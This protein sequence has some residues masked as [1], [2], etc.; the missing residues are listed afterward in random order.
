MGS[1]ISDYEYGIVCGVCSAPGGRIRGQAQ[2]DI[3]RQAAFGRRPPRGCQAHLRGERGGRGAFAS[4]VQAVVQGKSMVMVGVPCEQARAGG[5]AGREPRR[6]AQV[7][8][9]GGMLG[10]RGKAHR[11]S[12]VDDR[13]VGGGGPDGRVKDRRRGGGL[14]RSLRAV[15]RDDSA[16]GQDGAAGKGRDKPVREPVRRGR[17]LRGACGAVRRVLQH[18][19]Y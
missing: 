6:G 14:V 17:R 3:A 16:H 2:V 12:Q 11:G 7:W 13:G 10:Q 18:C 15:E 19:M 4:H 5:Q 9:A 8:I 1:C